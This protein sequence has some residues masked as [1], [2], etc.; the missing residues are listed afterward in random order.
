MGLLTIIKKQKIKDNEIRVLTLGLDNSGKTTII[1]N[2]LNEDTSTISPTMGFQINTFTHNGYTLN[3]WDIGG[4]TTIR[5]FWGNY[6]EKTNVVIWVVD[7]M[8]LE[9]LQESY[10]ELRE[11]VIL[12]DRLNGVYLL[13]LINK[14]DLIADK[15]AMDDI[16]Q[17]VLDTLNLEEQIPQRDKWAVLFVSGKTGEGIPSVLE[18]LTTREY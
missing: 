17:T 15:S 10:E 16:R 2:I 4:Q 14:I 13:I 11:K 5:N 3:V 6:F 12:Q 7:T 18:W 1:K 8:S 9:R